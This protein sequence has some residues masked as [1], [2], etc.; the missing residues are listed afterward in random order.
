MGR[1]LKR[2]PLDFNQPLNSVWS[3]FLN[4]HYGK[5]HNCTD[6]DG[7]G[8]TTAANRL[9]D[10]VSL[11]MLSG[12]DALQGR[13]HPYL[14][15]APL[16]STRGKA[17]GQ[18]MTDLTAGLAGRPPY[19]FGHDACDKYVATKKIVAAAGL[20]ESWGICQTCDG[21]GVIWD[22]PEDQQLAEAWTATQ[23]PTGEG[24]QI[25]ETVSEGS[26]ISPVFSTPEQLAAYMAG[27]KW[28]ADKGST[29]EQWMHFIK[30]PGWSASMLVDAHGVHTGPR[31]SPAY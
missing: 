22:S 5:K 25:W 14:I 21:E 11:L 8:S 9:S 4:P 3:G 18:D 20:P 28:G 17:C 30:G 26:P 6:C 23:P 10:L 24:Y 27:T 16:Y 13:C 15:E 19:S 2:V 31:A 12:S 1:E 7:T 29:Y